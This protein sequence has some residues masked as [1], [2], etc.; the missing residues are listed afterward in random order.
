[1]KK[2]LFILLVSGSVLGVFPQKSISQTIDFKGDFIRVNLGKIDHLE[3]VQSSDNKVSIAT[4][5]LQQEASFLKI[6]Q[7]KNGLFIN[8]VQTQVLQEELPACVEQ[9]LFTS[10][11]ISI[12]KD[13]KVF[14]TIKSGNFF[15]S[16]FNGFL[17]VQVQEGEINLKNILGNIKINNID[18]V[19]F[20]TTTIQHITAI[21]HLGKVYLQ[22][23]KPVTNKKSIKELLKI[24]SIRGNI[25]VNTNKTP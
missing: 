20:C 19:V 2:I 3:L 5:E 18:G 21:S 16:N 22:K 17:D 15:T 6:E 8:A 4:N 1:V 25:F 24:E 14:I 10:Y 23:R 13:V 7:E 12:P 9:P 11:K